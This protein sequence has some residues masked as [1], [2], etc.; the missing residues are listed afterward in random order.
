[1]AE[2]SDQERTE[3]PT[4]KRREEAR[5]KGDVAKSNEIPTAF[6]LLAA[7]CVF[8]F[9]APWMILEMT[10]LM[11]VCFENIATFHMTGVEL[12]AYFQ[13]VFRRAGL[14]LAPLFAVILIVAAASHVLQTGII[15]SITPL[16]PDFSKLDPVSGMK[17][18]FSQRSLVELAKSILKMAFIG[19]IT[20]MVMKGLLPEIPPLMHQGVGDIL[21]FTGGAC[22]RIA[23]YAG[24]GLVFLASLDFAFQRWHH[25]K[26]LRMTKQEIRDEQKQQEGDPQ[27]KARIK[28]I[29]MEMA[30][31]RMM[32]AIP[33]ADAVITNPDH[34]AVALKYDPLKM[35]APLVVAKGAGFLAQRI[36][37]VA[38]ENHIPLVENKPLARTLFKAVDIGKSIPEE[39]YRAVA[40]VLA[41]VYRLKE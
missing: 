25:G 29:Q 21:S 37:E 18:L 36:K 27:I 28:S 2:T 8:L 20:A 17:R 11:G 23:F 12:P 35:A 31:R 39:L 3:Q 41:Y 6:I 13:W 15:Y 40:E 16:T 32:S 5:K 1:M 38:R 9:T 22:L 33:E 24:L 14:L 30:R 4:P 19:T 7:L 10:G 34:L 26:K